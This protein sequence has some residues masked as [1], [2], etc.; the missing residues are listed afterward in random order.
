MRLLLEK[1]ASV[2]HAD[3]DGVTPL[4]VAC[5][6]DHE[7][8]ARLLLCKGATVDFARYDGITPL[9]MACQLGH[10]S[11]AR[12]LLGKGATVD[13]ARNDG[14]TPLCIA[15]QIDYESIIEP[16]SEDFFRN[17]HRDCS[18]LSSS[19][20]I[21][22]TRHASTPDFLR[23]DIHTVDS[24]TAQSEAEPA[25]DLADCSGFCIEGARPDGFSWVD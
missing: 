15:C 21:D 4:A 20:S 1:G 16:D 18:F 19:F 6:N 8:T 10:E 2:N 9:F 11:M 25:F 12:L 17:G 7:S 3:N 22:Y 14:G 5:T 24:A 13:L 23:F